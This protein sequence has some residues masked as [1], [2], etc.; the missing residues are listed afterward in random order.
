M[1]SQLQSRRPSQTLDDQDHL[2]H[3]IATME[4]ISQ[5]KGK[6]RERK[7]SE[8]VIQMCRKGSSAKAC[9]PPMGKECAGHLT[10]N[11]VAKMPSPGKSARL[12]ALMHR[13]GVPEAP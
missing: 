1:T 9:R 12:I 7:E 10:L 2:L 11:R 6:E 5:P 4:P 13:A 3:P 8:G